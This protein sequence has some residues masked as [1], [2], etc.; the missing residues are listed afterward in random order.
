[1]NEIGVNG[2]QYL[3]DALRNKV[4]SL[5]ISSSVSYQSS[6]IHTGTHYTES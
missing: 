4:V 3:A 2:T 6:P 5:I 1:M